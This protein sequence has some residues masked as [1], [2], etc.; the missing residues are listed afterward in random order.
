MQTGELGT[1]ALGGELRYGGEQPV[2]D[3]LEQVAQGEGQRADG[4]G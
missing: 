3:G 1:A 2:G 4:H